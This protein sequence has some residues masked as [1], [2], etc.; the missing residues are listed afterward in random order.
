MNVQRCQN[1]T[2]FQGKKPPCRFRLGGRQK[3]LHKGKMPQK[4]PLLQMIEHREIEKEAKA[5]DR[6]I[7]TL[8]Q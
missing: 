4:N 7:R 8:V 3:R 6:F 2:N 1:I 5:T